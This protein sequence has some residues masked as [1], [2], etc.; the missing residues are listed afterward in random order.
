M[1]KGIINAFDHMEF[2]L[3]INLTIGGNRAVA[4]PP[5]IATWNV[6]FATTLNTKYLL[7]TEKVNF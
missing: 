5:I 6:G 7:P 4:W 1:V 3:V 2:C